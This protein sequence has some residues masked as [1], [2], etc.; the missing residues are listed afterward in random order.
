MI[1]MDEATQIMQ[2]LSLA[3]FWEDD[4]FRDWRMEMESGISI[5]IKPQGSSWT[6]SIIRPDGS[7]WLSPQTYPS[8]QTAKNGLRCELERLRDTLLAD[9]LRLAEVSL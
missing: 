7:V 4:Q 8:V 1:Q 6:C 9:P 5:A 2:G 3:E